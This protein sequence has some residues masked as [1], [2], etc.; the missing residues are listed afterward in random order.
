LA[1]LAFPVLSWLGVFGHPEPLLIVFGFTMFILV[2]FTHKKNIIRL[3]NG[4]EN[5]VALFAKSK[6]GNR[7]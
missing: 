1:T 2:V 7:Q 6:V 5:R 4:N 3:M